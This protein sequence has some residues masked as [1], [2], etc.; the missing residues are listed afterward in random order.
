MT[1]GALVTFSLLTSH[2]LAPIVNLSR[3]AGILQTSRA[4]VDQ[5]GDVLDHPIDPEVVD[6][7]LDQLDQLETNGTRVRQ[8]SGLLEVKDV[9]FGYDRDRPPLIERLSFTLPAGGRVALVGRSGCGKSTIANLVAGLYAPWS[10][11]ILFDGHPRD[12]LARAVL[13]SSVAKVDPDFV[14][15]SGTVRDDLRFWDPSVDESRLVAAARDASIHDEIVRRPGGYGARVAEY[16]QNFSG[17]E[18]QRIEIARSL[19]TNP[20]LLILDE[21]TSA[22]DPETEQQID[23]AL[24]RRGLSCLVIAHRLS[25]IRDCDEIIVLDKGRVIQRGTHDQLIAVEGEYRT[26]VGEA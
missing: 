22:L 12:D 16:G 19:A 13:T 11:E 7:P 21:A 23:L 15:F 26:L 4:A 9:T 17:G 5:L 6:G 25:T 10:G 2:F 14:L 24:R 20:T 3:V 1:V 8:L 18:A